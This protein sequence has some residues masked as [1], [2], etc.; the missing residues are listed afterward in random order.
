MYPQPDH[1]FLP[2]QPYNVSGYHFGQRLRRRIILWATHLGDDV[3]APAGTAVCTTGAGEVVWAEIR[4]G[5]ARHRNWGG[6]IVIGHTA[7]TTSQPFFSIYGHLQDLTVRV[8]ETVAPQHCVGTIAPGLT[9][10]NGWWEIPHLHFGIYSGPWQRQ[11]LPG[12]KRPEEWRTRLRWW[13]DP[14]SFIEAYN[15]A[16]TSAPSN[17]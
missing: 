9:A 16:S 14:K 1:L 12:Y 17:S 15:L 11:V 3:I 10:E 5:T 8:G 7:R 4:R 13:H 2:I 6:L